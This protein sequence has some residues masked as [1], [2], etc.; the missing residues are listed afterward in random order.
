MLYLLSND[1][2][3]NFGTG[4]GQ[5]P[6]KSIAPPIPFTIFPGIIQLARSPLADTC[7]PPSMVR[8]TCPL[9]ERDVLTTNQNSLF[10]SRDWLTAN[11]GPVCPDLVTT[12]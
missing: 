8:S 7:R 3:D 1:L 9:K 12:R 4:Q 2:V 6:T 5:D 10:R 11:Q